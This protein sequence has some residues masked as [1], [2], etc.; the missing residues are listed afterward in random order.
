MGLK[1]WQVTPWAR[2]QSV[3]KKCGVDVADNLEARAAETQAFSLSVRAT[4][5]VLL[6]KAR[7]KPWDPPSFTFQYL[8]I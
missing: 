5:T 3:L 2:I 7:T 8:S 6:A 1:N 4:L